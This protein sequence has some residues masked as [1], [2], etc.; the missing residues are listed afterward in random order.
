MT[1]TTVGGTMP[2]RELGTA[3]GSVG[4]VMPSTGLRV[5]DPESGRDLGAGQRGELWV[6]GPQVMKGYLNRPDATAD[7]MEGEWLKTGDLGYVDED[8]NVFVVD[9]LKDL[10]KVSAYGV[11]PAELEALLLTHPQ[12]SDVAVVGRPDRAR[13]EVPVAA[14]VPRGE[15]GAEELVGWVAGWVAPHKRIREVRFV[16]AIPKTPSGKILRR[17]LVERERAAMDRVG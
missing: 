2:D 7:I 16:D 15:V 13:G 3:P 12:V 4:R 5:V 1:E 17:V 6:R 14:V 9:R 10:I 8:S 11:A